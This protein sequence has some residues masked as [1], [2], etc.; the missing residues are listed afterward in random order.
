[1]PSTGPSD[2]S[3]EKAKIA[4]DTSPHAR[5]STIV[6]KTPAIAK[7]ASARHIRP[8]ID[9]RASERSQPPKPGCPL[10]RQRRGAMSTR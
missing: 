7:F 6:P 1:M 3:G 4:D 8:S 10:P 5:R 2:I 9:C